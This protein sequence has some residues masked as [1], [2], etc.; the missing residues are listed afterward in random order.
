MTNSFEISIVPNPTAKIEQ[1]P[2]GRYLVTITWAN[3]EKVM[4]KRDYL[5]QVK[6]DL[7]EW[8]VEQTDPLSYLY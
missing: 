1:L 5:F 7:E 2:S 6:I 3:G 4:L 8:G